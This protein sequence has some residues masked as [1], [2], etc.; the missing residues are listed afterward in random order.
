MEE[1]LVILLYE[2][3]IKLNQILKEQLSIQDIYQ[4]HEATDEKNLIQLIEILTIN[5][6][7]LNLND[8]SENLKKFLQGFNFK[9]KFIRSIGY[10]NKDYHFIDI[11]KM[12]IVLLEKPFRISSLLIELEKLL[13]TNSFQNSEIFLMNDLKFLPYKKVLIN[14]NSKNKEHLTEKENK[15]LLYLCNNKNIEITKNV[16]LSSIWGISESINTHT[17]ETHI[18]RLKQKLYKLEPKSPFLLTNNNGLYS[19]KF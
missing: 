10:Y 6:L 14:L 3:E 1:K 4:I 9:N 13:S 18:Y 5:L 7:I 11:E 15:L 8:I 19:F 16:L 12:E 17:L 2:K